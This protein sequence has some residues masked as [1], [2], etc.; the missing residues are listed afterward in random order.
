MLTCCE[1]EG[2]V[3]V[4]TLTLVE[5]VAPFEAFKICRDRPPNRFD[6]VALASLARTACR[7]LFGINCVM[8]GGVLEEGPADVV[9]LFS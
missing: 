1:E 7:L 5:A 8:I 4:D 9:K 2:S 3:L 6:C